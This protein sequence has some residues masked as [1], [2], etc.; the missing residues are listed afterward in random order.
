MFQDFGIKYNLDYLDNC[1]HVGRCSHNVLDDVSSGLLQVHSV[2]LWNRYGISNLTLYLI[3][4][5][6]SVQ[7]SIQIPEFDKIHLEKKK[8]H[9]QRLHQPK[10]CGND[11]SDESSSLNNLN[12][13]SSPPPPKKNS[14][15]LQQLR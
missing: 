2:E 9:F 12:Y 11:I 14:D 7:N 10:R 4:I 3:H 8:K 5:K 13:Q 6:D 1:S 15:R